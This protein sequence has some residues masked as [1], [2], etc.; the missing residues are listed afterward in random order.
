MGWKKSDSHEGTDER[1][2]RHA[3]IYHT[4]KRGKRDRSHKEDFKISEDESKPK[5]LDIKPPKK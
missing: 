1:I 5:V 2:G 4:D 3:D